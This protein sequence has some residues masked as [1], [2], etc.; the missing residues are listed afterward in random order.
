LK[1]PEL[2]PADNVSFQF[3][4]FPDNALLDLRLDRSEP[5]CGHG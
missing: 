5:I 1:N 2:T 3:S 4:V